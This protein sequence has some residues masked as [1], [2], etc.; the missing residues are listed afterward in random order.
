MTGKNHHRPAAKLQKPDLFGL[1]AVREALFNT[2]RAFKNIYV[3]KNRLEEVESLLNDALKK[4]LKRPRPQVIDRDAFSRMFPDGTV[5]QGVAATCA[6]LPE[7]YLHE[8]L[9]KT[10]HKESSVF[11]MLDQVTDP[12]NV[13][14]IIRSA[15]AFGADGLIVQKRHAPPM[16]GI[17]AKTACGALEHL[18]IC[19]ETN[20]A[21]SIELL[22]EHGYTVLGLD[23]RGRMTFGEKM[24]K[25]EKVALVLGAEGDG[26]RRLTAEKC[27]ALVK[28]PTQGEILSLNVSNAAAVALYA[29]MN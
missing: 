25:F 13:G 16:N 21:R 18:P 17:L 15:S 2:D 22:Q 14:A 11:L 7:T 20:L 9:M 12:H 27:D 3:S 4:G 23:E 26:L 1:H 5:H 24:P 29:V 6:P 19:A 8:L 28:L 10:A